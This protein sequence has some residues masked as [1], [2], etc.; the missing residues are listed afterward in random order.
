MPAKTPIEIEARD[1]RIDELKVEIQ[2]RKD[3]SLA[4]ERNIA[5]ANSGHLGDM[6]SAT[7]ALTFMLAPMGE[8]LTLTT[9]ERMRDTQKNLD[10]GVRLIK[11]SLVAEEQAKAP[12]GGLFSS[13]VKAAQ[14]STIKFLDTLFNSTR[15]QQSAVG[16]TDPEH[17]KGSIPPL[18]DDVGEISEMVN[19]RDDILQGLVSGLLEKPGNFSEKAVLKDTATQEYMNRVLGLPA[20]R[21]AREA[22]KHNLP[23][24]AHVLGEI[25]NMVTLLMVTRGAGVG[26]GITTGTGLLSRIAPGLSATAKARPFLSAS[27][28]VTA[29][30]GGG[31][32]AGLAGYKVKTMMD[33]TDF[34]VGEATLRAMQGGT[35]AF[36]VMS[37]LYGK[38]YG[39][40]AKVFHDAAMKV[41]NASLLTRVKAFGLAHKFA[42]RAAVGHMVESGVLGAGFHTF[43]EMSKGVPSG[44]AI[45]TGLKEAP[46]WMMF[47]LV[48]TQLGSTLRWTN[49]ITDVRKRAFVIA[50]QLGRMRGGQATV[51]GMEV[52]S[53]VVGRT[54]NVAGTTAVGAG[55]GAGIATGT[56][57]DPRAGAILGA[58]AGMGQSLLFLNRNAFL[59][60][61][62]LR[63]RLLKGEFDRLPPKEAAEAA[64]IIMHDAASMAAT[65]MD[66]ATRLVFMRAVGKISGL[67]SDVRVEMLEGGVKAMKIIKAQ[68]V[69]TGVQLHQLSPSMELLTDPRGLIQQLRLGSKMFQ[70]REAESQI[71]RRM[72]LDSKQPTSFIGGVPTTEGYRNAAVGRRKAKRFVEQVRT[73]I[74][75]TQ[76]SA[77]TQQAAR[78]IEEE[79]SLAA[80][81]RGA[82]ASREA[83]RI[84]TLRTEINRIRD[85]RLNAAHKSIAGMEIKEVF[86]E[87]ATATGE[88]VDDVIKRSSPEFTTPGLARIMDNGAARLELAS[89]RS[90]TVTPS[91]GITGKVLRR[92]GLTSELKRDLRGFESMFEEIDNLLA[93]SDI[94]E[95]ITIEDVR[96]MMRK[97]GR[98]K[99]SGKTGGV[100]T[101]DFPF[102]GEM[103]DLAPALLKRARLFLKDFNPN[104]AL[105]PVGVGASLVEAAYVDA[106]GGFLEGTDNDTGEPNMWW[107]A[108]AA[109]SMLGMVLKPG[110]PLRIQGFGKAARNLL[111]RQEKRVFKNLGTNREALIALLSDG[112]VAILPGTSTTVNLSK[113]QS[114]IR[115]RAIVMSLHNHPIKLA[116]MVADVKSFRTSTGK[117]IKKLSVAQLEQ[118]GVGQVIWSSVPSPSDY[119]A[120]AFLGRQDAPR[121]MGIIT[122]IEGSITMVQYTPRKLG[123]KRLNATVVKSDAERARS[124]IILRMEAELRKVRKDTNVLRRT[125]DGQTYPPSITGE[126]A[127]HFGREATEAIIDQEV[128]SIGVR[129]LRNVSDAQFEK[130]TIEA[131]SLTRTKPDV[132][133]AASAL[134]AVQMQTHNTFGHFARQGQDRVKVAQLVKALTGAP[135]RP[136]GKVPPKP[137]VAPVGA[138]DVS[139]ILP[140]SVT[141][142]EVS[143]P[144]QTLKG[145][146]AWAAT[147]GLRVSTARDGNGALVF[148]TTNKQGTLVAEAPTIKGMLDD[149]MTTSQEQARLAGGGNS[150]GLLRDEAL[151]AREPATK[152]NFFRRRELNTLMFSKEGAPILGF[153]VGSLGTNVLRAW[154]TDPEGDEERSQLTPI[155]VGLA[156]A[157]AA[158]LANLGLGRFALKGQLKEV[159]RI[160]RPDDVKPFPRASVDKMMGKSSVRPKKGDKFKFAGGPTEKQFLEGFTPIDQVNH[161]SKRLDAIANTKGKNVGDLKKRFER[162]LRK[163]IPSWIPDG[164]F[165]A[166][167]SKVITGAVKLGFS[168]SEAIAMWHGG[169]LRAA[170]VMGPRG[171]SNKGIDLLSLAERKS[172]V[173]FG[174]NA[175]LEDV[176]AIYRAAEFVS[177]PPLPSPS[178]TVEAARINAENSLTNVAKD[179]RE[180]HE[181]AAGRDVKLAA[182][183]DGIA[184]S[185][186][187]G[188]F[189]I[190]HH[191]LRSP[192]SFR[193]MAERLALTPD[194][195]GIANQMMSLFDAVNSATTNM[196]TESKT[197]GAR[198]ARI[199]T[200]IPY[201]DRLRVPDLLQDPAEMEAARLANPRLHNAAAEFRRF[202]TD[203]ADKLQIPHQERVQD[204]FTWIYNTKTLREM[205]VKG[206]ASRN[207]VL[208]P[209]HSGTPE[210]KIFNHMRARTRDTPLGAID[211]DPLSVGSIYANGA[212]RKFH[213]DNVLAIHDN[214][215]FKNFSK[216][217]PFVALDMTNWMLDSFGV[218]GQQQMR[219]LTRLRAAGIRY[220]DLARATARLGLGTT[221]DIIQGI[222]DRYFFG[223]GAGRRFSNFARSFEFY[224]KLGANWISP[225]VNLSQLYI[226]TGADIG[227]VN[228]MLGGINFGAGTLVGKIK[229][230]ADKRAILKAKS[231]GGEPQF[232]P[233]LAKI[234]AKFSGTAK[235][236]MSQEIGVLS[237]TSQRLIDDMHMRAR[238][239]QGTGPGIK[240]GAM[241]AGAAIGSSAAHI[242]GADGDT[243]LVA[244][245]TG[246]NVAIATVTSGVI[247]LRASTF[248]AKVFRKGLNMAKQG[249]V[250]PFAAAE[251]FNRIM[252]AGGGLRAVR[253]AQAVTTAAGRNR[254]QL[255]EVAGNVALGTTVAGGLD[256]TATEGEDT[257]TNLTGGAVVGAAVG[258]LGRNRTRSRR[259]VPQ[260][261]RIKQSLT[262]N[263]SNR[264][265]F[266]DLAGELAKIGPPTQKEVETWWVR[267]LLDQTQFRFGREGRAQIFRSNTYGEV[268]GSLQSFT[269]NQIEFAGSRMNS[270]WT[271][272]IKAADHPG[273]SKGV[274]R[275]AL[276]GEVDVRFLRHL[277]LIAGAGS[278]MTFLAGSLG[279]E[280]SNLYWMSRIG[281]GLMP[282]LRWNQ[283]AETWQIGDLAQQFAGPFISDVAHATNTA[284]HLMTNPTAVRKFDEQL[285]ELSIKLFTAFR[286][287]PDT[288][289]RIGQGMGLLGA[290]HHVQS[291]RNQQFGAGQQVKQLAEQPVS[292]LLGRARTERSRSPASTTTD[293]FGGG[294]GG[295]GFGSEF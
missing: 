156:G 133:A 177:G 222:S 253:K 247:G 195:Q 183:A 162:T 87:I 52:V 290:E 187:A 23:M 206:V 30:T 142:Q 141:P 74:D 275:T 118:L 171:R 11:N 72:A 110:F 101:A 97:F 80:A 273:T 17:F 49:L 109:V 104:M 145:A 157:A 33:Q 148:R 96:R 202:Q 68:M 31:A 113:F 190:I 64:E 81:V 10:A 152:E 73:R 252:T 200:D 175:T 3:F 225:M 269:I 238:F 116:E 129:M 286:Q 256:V 261:T 248:G 211:P 168:E 34:E 165:V 4:L 192:E 6:E 107:T 196:K 32:A 135:L 83:G 193:T 43:E 38:P 78:N 114:T 224:S 280:K 69:Q 53:S 99:V 265:G 121:I 20:G 106:N 100:I 139:R 241:F 76:E 295:G 27:V 257:A 255:A 18:V 21:Q 115:G 39:Q 210:Y 88:K 249:I 223:Q 48:G 122:P 126:H 178:G 8:K 125:D 124:K 119:G 205:A 186:D 102:I 82:A 136:K 16:G 91:K 5:G 169:L 231:L 112:G 70:L 266:F 85:T 289:T 180:L 132:I 93:K 67:P 79:A 212:I 232:S 198:L 274:L 219:A 98:G 35:I 127:L 146:R 209:M 131:L 130:L 270:M 26:K 58:A 272:M 54:A 259:I 167:Q 182:A 228:I 45:K 144:T 55:I 260:L 226:N 285:D 117:Q 166:L 24:S 51:R 294:F 194:T 217:E 137:P 188:V 108:A 94:G 173:L 201:A 235:F 213:M 143:K 189:G 15:E 29:V 160:L 89:L 292:S 12:V 229:D 279:S 184:E 174:P 60:S 227:M 62:G 153:L 197:W 63:N 263:P 128:E 56:G 65:E 84:D 181:I 90:G 120:M 233:L 95:A 246:L 245:L 268:A 216:S 204:Y 1:A 44:E 161:L 236:R 13:M 59:M 267:Q 19:T 150:F 158:A 111:M 230:I 288:T 207:S 203:L 208:V 154:L 61:K 293:S 140:D 37:M 66:D 14:S 278:A 2:R 36:T 92:Q 164:S 287:I 250:A 42:P 237:D 244:G 46:T 185:G 172:P 214:A 242:A 176:H 283:D 221:S 239:D 50:G 163:F 271:S 9:R 47:D 151:A 276:A 179:L 251:S 134:Q 240:I 284:W 199:F 41:Q 123:S 218:P 215:W 40:Q 159:F 105:A 25:A 7:R 262:D 75:T 254:E 77:A 149:L 22:F 258:L 86:E 71:V 191:S 155:V 234:D 264:L 170:E 147:H 281:F 220:E 103:S 138:R 243:Q 282:F 28:G 277:A 291:F 57:Q